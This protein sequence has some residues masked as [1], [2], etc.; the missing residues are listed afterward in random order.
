MKEKSESFNTILA[1]ELPDNDRSGLPVIARFLIAGIVIVLAIGLSYWFLR[2]CYNNLY[3]NNTAF[4]LKNIQIDTD[5]DYLKKVVEY[6]L[7]KNGIQAGIST[8]PAIPIGNIRKELL[9]NPRLSAVEVRRFYPDSLR[10]KL[11]ARVPVAILRFSPKYNR[12]ELKI[13]QYGYVVPFDLQSVDTVL[14]TVIGLGNPS[15]YVPGQQTQNP[16]VLAFLA[17]LRESKLR[18][19][20]AM[21]EVTICRLDQQQEVMQLI[22]EARGPFKT[23]ARLITPTKD[24][25]E[26]L[27]RIKVIVNARMQ[28]NKTI[29]YLNATYENIPI[30]P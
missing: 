8:L 18:P 24:I 28:E 3:Y 15:E 14:P 2:A 1:T 22:L 20:G 5:N 6:T 26:N 16:S 12:P 17:F 11:T 29:S 27:D 10:V 4:C 23:S 25:P 13:D 9:T 7:D 19:E 21:Y 30:R